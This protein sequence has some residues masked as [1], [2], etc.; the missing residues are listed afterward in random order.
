MKNKKPKILDKIYALEDFEYYAKKHLPKPVYGYVS[1]G[2]ERNETLNGNFQDLSKY[3]FIPNILRD[4]SKRSIKTSIFG[5]EWDAP[6]GISPMGVSAL[7]AYRGDLVLAESARNKNIPMMI[8]GS[9]LIPMEDI[10]KLAPETWFQAYLPG[11]HDKVEGL[12]ERVKNAGFKTLVLTVDVSV[13]AGR[14]NNL[15]NGF[16]TPLRP[17]LK[18]LYNGMIRPKWSINTFLKTILLH[19]MPHFENFLAQRGEPV[20]S[21]S[22]NRDFG[23]RS[24][25]NWSHMKQIRDLWDGN[26]I[27]KGIL[28]KDDAIKASSFGADAIII[29]N[30]GGRQLDS[31]ISSIKALENIRPHIKDNCKLFIDSGF[32]RGTDV[33]K[34]LSIGADFVF[35]GRPFLYAASIAGLQGVEHAINLLMDEIDRDIALIGINNLTELNKQLIYSY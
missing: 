30:H 28:N 15:R 2:A 6:F 27:V 19:G 10:I 32:R 3:K 26:L 35:I 5:Q 22:V 4:V 34:A 13:L 24:N 23:K 11:E 17:S 29:S 8:S 7:A 20:F 21:A 1:G 33:I 12:V 9:S 25:L 18:L 16:S 14:E 31:A